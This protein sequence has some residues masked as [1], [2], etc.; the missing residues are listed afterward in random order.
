MDKIKRITPIR[1]VPGELP[2]KPREDGRRE[3]IP[4]EEKMPEPEVPVAPE[5]KKESVDI[6]VDGVTKEKP[7]DVDKEV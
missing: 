5:V 2:R 3:T 7:H 4:E 1:P 6:T